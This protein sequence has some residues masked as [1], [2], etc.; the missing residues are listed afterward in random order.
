MAMDNYVGPFAVPPTS[1]ATF[2]TIGVIV[3]I[4]IYDA[5]LVLLARRRTGKTVAC[6]SLQR[7]GVGL[8]LSV[9]AMACVSAGDRG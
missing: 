5:T 1:L 6:R 9:V 2:H 7:L 8:A 3:G 4:P